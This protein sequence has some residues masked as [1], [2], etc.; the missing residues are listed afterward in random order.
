M[1]QPYQVLQDDKHLQRISR[2]PLM[3]GVCLTEVMIGLVAGTIVLAATLGTFNTIHHHII[4]QQRVLAYQQDLRL[5]LEVFEQEAHLAEAET[6]TAA[7]PDEFLFS[8]NLHAQWTSTTG[9]VAPGQT[10]LTV[11]DGSNW[12]S[13]KTVL[14]CGP[15]VCEMHR[16]ARAGQRYQLVLAEPVRG[17][18]P[19]GASLEVR[20][21]VRYYTRRD[22]SGTVRLMRMVDGG[23]S[24]LIGG[25][26]AISFSYR[27][28]SG[29]A[30]SVPAQIKRVVVEIESEHPTRRAVREVSLR[31]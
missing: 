13:G 27:D 8:A 15:H 6:I 20:N 16:L 25:I 9:S 4:D 19:A 2:L 11:Q 23:A 21:R 24:T 12:G 26:G 30:T 10:V 18:F 17:V 5:G 29:R 22:E 28:S 14:L 1:S 3:S 31:S 7:T